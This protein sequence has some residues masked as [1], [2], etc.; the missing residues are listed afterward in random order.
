MV[1]EALTAGHVRARLEKLGYFL[2]AAV[3]VDERQSS[4]GGIRRLLKRSSKSGTG[5]PGR[6]EFIAWKDGGDT[7]VVIECK[8][9]AE[10]HAS[11]GLDRPEEYALDGALHY[12][13]HLKNRYNVAAVA[14]S[15]EDPSRMKTSV[16]YWRKGEPVYEDPVQ[17]DRQV[18]QVRR[19]L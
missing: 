14:V 10:R 13:S 11:E 7:V 16:F 1:N 19:R 4:S 5:R 12:A 6:P 2:D 17:G 15:G 3:H 8:A 18:R 9:A